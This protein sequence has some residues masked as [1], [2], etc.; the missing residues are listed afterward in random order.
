[1]NACSL[2]LNLSDAISDSFQSDRAFFGAVERYQTPPT[3]PTEYRCRRVRIPDNMDFIAAVNEL[4]SRLC[5]PEMWQERSGGLTPLEASVLANEMY[6]DYAESDDYCMIGDVV[7][8]LRATLPPNKLWCDGSTYLRTDYPKLYAV[9]D[10]EFIVDADHFIVP[11]LRRR[12]VIGADD[13]YPVNASGGEATHTLTSGEMPSHTHVQD[14]HNHTQDSH[15]HSQNSHNHTQD[16]H[17]H[18]QNSHNHT[19]NSHGHTGNS[20]GHSITDPGHTH[21]QNAHN[22]GVTDPGH[23]HNV[24][25]KETSAAGTATQLMAGNATGGISSRASVS[26]T[27]GIT[28]NNATAINQSNTTGISI[29]NSVISVQDATATNQATTATNNAVTATNQATTATNNATTA[30]NQ[31]T[32]AT[33]QNTGGGGAHNNM[34]PYLALKYAVIAK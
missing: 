28:T 14:S 25:T 32:T 34:Q 17:N 21:T 13:D 2:A 22:H 29:D 15:N 11:D 8:V 26:N 6:D 7:P 4:L 10:S 9:L 3:T 31:A 33:N 19:Q 12:T 20:H 23:T 18:S 1:M 30:T 24:A 16:S 27:T 5:F